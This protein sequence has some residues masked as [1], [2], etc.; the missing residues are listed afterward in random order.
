MTILLMLTF[1][2]VIAT[3]TYGVVQQSKID[4]FGRQKIKKALKINLGVFI[5]VMMGALIVNIPSVASA[6]GTVAVNPAA[7][8]GYLA[9]ALSTGLATL[10]AGYAVGAVGSSALGAVSE[11]PKI[12]GKTLIFVGLGEG[13][14]IYGLIV[15]IMIL[16]K[17]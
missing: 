12:L 1:C 2:V 3:I 11:D 10:G 5:P 8:I 9:A 15:S 7:G 17:L 13:I 4:V 16:A 6:A 14:A